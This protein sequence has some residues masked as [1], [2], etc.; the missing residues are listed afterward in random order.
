MGSETEVAVSHKD[1]FLTARKNL[2]L[3]EQFSALRTY[4]D[5]APD[6]KLRLTV[7]LTGTVD[8]GAHA[9]GA[10]TATTP[11]AQPVVNEAAPHSHGAAG[12][13]MDMSAMGTS[14]DMTTMM[15]THH[16]SIESIQWSDPTNSD[17]VNTTNNVEW[18]I[19]DEAT[20][21]KSMSI[22]VS[23]WTF[24]QGSLVKIRI[25]NDMMAAHVMQHPIHLHGQRFV[26]LSENGILNQN[27]AW[28]DTALVLPGGY[29]DILVDMSNLGEWMLHCH[30]SEHLHAGM[31]MPFRV[32][33][34]SGYAVGDEFRKSVPPSAVSTGSAPGTTLGNSTPQLRSNNFA[35]VVENNDKITIESQIIKKG[36]ESYLTL[37]FTDAAGAPI[38][39][40]SNMKYPL[41]VTFVDRNN[42]I[43]YVTYPGNTTFPASAVPATQQQNV[44][45]APGFNESMP[46]SHSF[47]FINTVY[48]HNGVNDGHP[49]LRSYSV[50][51]K[52]PEA[53]E[54]RG[55]VEY[56]V[57]GDTKPRLGV[58]AVTVV[59]STTV[60]LQEQSGGF[61][62]SFPS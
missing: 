43:R 44:P 60:G 47:N 49:G 15:A 50:P 58:I 27:M 26:V 34:Q 37:S 2:E 1:T 28:K 56:T 21:K 53:G 33:D 42:A 52:F 61:F 55:F 31:M 11:T 25:T 13:P 59:K 3:S 54:Y 17:A 48:A 16:P 9:H 12:T 30:I 14:M 57:E 32:E 41:A 7:A 46:H 35:D 40:D 51:V 19:V 20:G 29:I 36:V 39:L 6:K 5:R 4:F 18:I 62:L 22:P 23:D 45:G 8:H 24:K 10:T 38:N